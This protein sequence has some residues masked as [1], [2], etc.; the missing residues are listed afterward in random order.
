MNAPQASPVPCEI[1]PRLLCQ[2]WC[3]YLQP[4]FLGE[5]TPIG[6]AL[7]EARLTNGID[8]FVASINRQDHEAGGRLD[9]ITAAGKARA[10][11]ERMARFGVL[12]RTDPEV[13]RRRLAR[14][15]RSRAVAPYM[16]PLERARVEDSR[17]ETTEL[18]AGL[19]MLAQKLVKKWELLL[20]MWPKLS[21]T[22]QALYRWA[23]GEALRYTQVRLDEESVPPLLDTAKAFLW[24][25]GAGPEEIALFETLFQEFKRRHAATFVKGS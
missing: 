19:T 25:R 1:H 7:C 21:P 15:V 11:L 4:F 24:A 23:F 5:E 3:P 6:R 17:A 16:V 8:A 18:S 2:F 10:W 9:E 22:H 20:L 14:Y 12:A 13:I